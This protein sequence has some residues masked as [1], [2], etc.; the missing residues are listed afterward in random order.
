M[1]GPRTRT[2]HLLGAR[3]RISVN[4]LGRALQGERQ[5]VFVT[6]SSCSLRAAQD[7]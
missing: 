6:G 1:A 4:V 3:W 7:D 5:V 2:P